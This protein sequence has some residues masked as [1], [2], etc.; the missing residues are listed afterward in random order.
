MKM[1]TG[2]K[3][4]RSRPAA[5]RNLRRALVRGTKGG[6]PW[7]GVQNSDAGSEHGTKDTGGI[8]SFTDE[9]GRNALVHRTETLERENKV[10]VS[11]IEVGSVGWVKNWNR[12][13]GETWCWTNRQWTKMTR[14]PATETKWAGDDGK[15]ED[16]RTNID[17]CSD[18]LQAIAHFLDK[19]LDTAQARNH[20]DPVEWHIQRT[21]SDLGKEQEK[22]Q[23]ETNT[24]TKYF[25]HK[26]L[27]E[28]YIWNTE[29][30]ALPPSFDYWKQNLVL[31]TL[32]LV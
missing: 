30:T 20:H 5:K 9:N 15:T 17:A 8:E 7:V 4:Q 11:K 19:T 14:V 1:K 3:S 29:V 10:L 26:N 24:K 6:K 12:L 31:G 25:L 22:A 18:G 2:R 32:L 21:R 23:E 28:V 13:G 27:N 16:S